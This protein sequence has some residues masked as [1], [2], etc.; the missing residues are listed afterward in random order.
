M[1]W[2]PSALFRRA[3]RPSRQQPFRKNYRPLLE[4]LETRLAPSVSVLTYHNDNSRSGDNLNETILTPANV[5]SADFGKL[6]SVSVDGQVYAQPLYVPN[7]SLTVAGLGPGKHNVVY[8]A[9]EHDS[10]YAI[11]AN[12][13]Q[14]LWHDSFINPA[15]GITTVPSTDVNTTDLTP[16]IGITATPVIDPTTKT[17]YVETKTKEVRGTDNHYVQKLYAIDITNGAQKF[18]GPVTIAD[19]I[20]NGGA[21]F[22]YVS[23]PYVF[24]TGDGNVNGVVT[25]NALRQ[26]VRTALTLANGNI[27]MGSA[28]HGD[29]NPYHGWVLSYNAQTLQLDGVFNST[30]NAGQGG[31]WQGG[32]GVAVDAQG[33]IYFGTGNGLFDSTLNS[34]G[35]P[36]QG[37]YGDSI[38]KLTVDSSTTA[39][40]QN[41]NGWGFKVV[42]YFTPFDQNLLNIGDV[43]LAS[44]G[45]TLLP[46]S[47]GS[48][49]HPN[50]MLAAGK[51]GR[52]Y[53]IDQNN[54]GHYSPTTDNV[55][56]HASVI[57]G[58]YS[59]PAYFNGEFYYAGGNTDTLKAFSIADGAFNTTPTSQSSDTFGTQ[60]ATA[61]ISAN[62]AINAIVWILDRASNQLRAYDAT[63]LADELYTSAQAP[64]GRDQV[65]S[66]VKF[67][68]PT[69]ADGQVFVGT[70]NSLLVYGL[71]NSPTNLPAAPTSLVAQASSGNQI[72]LTWA[73]NAANA[74]VVNVEVSTDGINFTP[75]T[76]VGATVH[77]YLA[78]GLQPSTAYTFRVNAVNAAGPSGYS[79]LASATT[80]SSAGSGLDMSVGFAGASG[81]LSANGSAKIVGPVLQL[82]DG[83]VNEA[84]S[85]FSLSQLNAA[86]F[87]TQFSFQLLNANADGFT[88]TLQGQGANA[89][90][91]QGGSLGYGPSTSGGIAKSVAVKF[92]LFN[93]Q[94]GAS[95]STGLL[96]NGAATSAGSINLGNAGINLHSGDLFIVSMSY[97]GVTLK[98]AITDT[99]TGASASQSYAIN[100]PAAVGGSTAYFG[101]TGGSGSQTAA[102]NILGWVYSPSAAGPPAAPTALNA[103]AVSASEGALSWTSGNSGATSF[104]VERKSSGGNYSQIAALVGTTSY[105]DTGL[106]SG[107]Q[108][109]YRV[110]APERDRYVGLLRGDTGHLAQSSSG[111][112]EPSSSTNRP[113]RG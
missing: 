3:R 52:V 85:A 22:T 32:D 37:D 74:N 77:S 109:T 72:N 75:L 99:I 58:S 38:I 92:D 20:W 91:Q 31:T 51:E 33:N 89:L 56:Q 106:N 110:R 17:I 30:P 100:I 42:D 5:N 25:F 2:S 76:T 112:D 60:G 67:S 96:V 94:S 55:V 69:V 78:V 66:V 68:V 14:V 107:G 6:L 27:Y 4:P 63:N 97:D 79:N 11:D 83:N 7:V 98:V 45:V 44:G 101:F 46:A 57:G 95:N 64:K 113:D 73:N 53:L 21:T 15:A 54:M 48:A 28:S 1:K 9:T 62:G 102:Q 24:G 8:V 103:T 39:T 49:A 41:Q 111:A 47:A 65:G 82:T 16:E 35:F 61:S 19:T 36:S 93:N 105:L 43:D 18:G 80:Q 34:Q 87:S 104:L 50:L 29:N 84:G 12:S 70:S 90:G 26:L 71:F 40:H 86:S 10:L 59:T 88:F 13:G 23:G 108:Y 81:L